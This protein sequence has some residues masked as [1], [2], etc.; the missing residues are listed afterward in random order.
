MFSDPHKILV[1]FRIYLRELSSD[2]TKAYYQMTTV[3][4]EKH[5]RRMVWRNGVKTARWRIFGYRCVS[6]GDLP[7]AAL[8][9]I[10]V[11]LPIKM[12][13]DIDL[14]ATNLLWY[15]HNVDRIY[16]GG[17]DEKVRRFKGFEDPETLL[18]AGTMFRIMGSANLIL[19][20]IAV[21]GET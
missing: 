8:L 1:R 17:S 4:V 19:K 16:S 12:F 7:V 10:C 18:C 15:N 20:A 11:K 14:V 9:E 6:S 5:V 13:T 3:L 2:V 21:S